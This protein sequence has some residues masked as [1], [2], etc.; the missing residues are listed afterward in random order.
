VTDLIPV[1]LA[2]NNDQGNHSGKLCAIVI[3]GGSLD[4]DAEFESAYL[5]APIAVCRYHSDVKQLQIGRQ[6]FP[7]SGYKTWYGNM[8]WDGAFVEPKVSGDILLWL[9]H[10]RD[11][12]HLIGGAEDLYDAW[13]N[14][15]TRFLRRTK[16]GRWVAVT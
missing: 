9:W 15:T 12:V 4:V 11:R 14:E 16:T 3:G 6:R 2:V 1:A 10:H 8:L 13:K 5:D 7:V